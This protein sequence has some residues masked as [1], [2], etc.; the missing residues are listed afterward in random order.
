MDDVTPFERRKLWLLN[1]SHSL[2]AYAG[3]IRGHETIDAAIADPEPRSWVEAFWDEAVRHLDLP[4]PALAEYRT[5]LLARFGNPRVRHLLAQIAA[6]GSMKLPVRIVPTLVAEREAGRQPV[7]AATAVAA[8]VLHLRG[9]GAPIKD[10]ASGPAQQA[11]AAEP[12]RAAVQG[13]LEVLRPGLGADQ[14]LVALVTERAEV[15]PPT[16]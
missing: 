10:P 8:W 11:A 4:G 5:A 6:D 16:T 2:L 14:E 13:V 3:S 9:H 7:G 15:L 12:L 1:G